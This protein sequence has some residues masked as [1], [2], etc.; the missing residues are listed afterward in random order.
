[1]QLSVV[2]WKIETCQ[3]TMYWRRLLA[4]ISWFNCVDIH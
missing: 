1:M 4:V 3:L 2:E